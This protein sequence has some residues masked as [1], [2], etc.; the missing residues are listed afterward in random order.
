MDTDGAHDLGRLYSA[1]QH[2]ARKAQDLAQRDDA[3]DRRDAA[4]HAGCAIELIAKAVLVSFDSRLIAPAQDLHHVLLD[5]VVEGRGATPT[6]PR[7]GTQRRK[8]IDA[9]LAVALT[10][11]LHEELRAHEA[12]ATT[13][14][15]ARNAAA[16]MAI[17]DTEALREVLDGMAAYV[18]AALRVLR[19]TSQDFWGVLAAEMQERATARE[20]TVKEA[21][22]LKVSEAADL[23]H[24]MVDG[25]DE[26]RRASLLQTLSRR[27]PDYGFSD[28]FWTLD[29][30]ACGYQDARLAW[31]A[32]YDVERDSQGG[33]DAVSGG[34]ALLG[35]Q[36]P[37]CQLELDADEVNA[38]GID[39]DDPRD[40]W[41][42]DGGY[43][44]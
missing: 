34:L 43:A 32:D 7:P 30:P 10:G 42:Y 24:R 33:Y 1:A 2:H 15:A 9:G 22:E 11:R 26:E 21:A 18:E 12:A 40:P 25:L 37:V 17:C 16:H 28:D 4:L 38:L 8:T 23:Y 19:R 29:C 5:V 31:V 3:H 20:R 35:L 39:T 6:G 27:E 13:A 36:C 14:L 41:E 44:D